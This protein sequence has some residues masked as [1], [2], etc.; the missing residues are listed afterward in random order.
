MDT[1]EE[2]REDYTNYFKGVLVDGRIQRIQLGEDLRDL[3]VLG[4]E[5]I[6]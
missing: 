4:D 1:L 5:A 3:G 2:S 6:L